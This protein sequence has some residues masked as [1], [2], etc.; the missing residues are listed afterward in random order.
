MDTPSPVDPSKATPNSGAPTPDTPE[1]GWKTWYARERIQLV[2]GDASRFETDRPKGADRP[3]FHILGTCPSCHHRTSA[4]CAAKY[5]AVDPAVPETARFRADYRPRLQA[6]GPLGRRSGLPRSKRAAGKSQTMITVV[7]CGCIHNHVPPAD[8]AFGC[9]SEWLLRVTFDSAGSP[10]L[11]VVPEDEA[12]RV[13]PAAEE[14]ASHVPTSLAD[15]QATAKNWAA[16]L[17]AVLT[18]LGAGSLLAN[19][20]TVQTLSRSWQLA[21]GVFAFAAVIANGVMLYQSNF[22]SY[23]SPKINDALS[24][25]DPEV[26]DLD[27]L[28]DA[29]VSVRKLQI[30]VRMTVLAVVCALIAIGILLFV[31]SAPPALQPATS[32][33]T[34]RANGVITTTACGT[35]V[36]ST[37]SS[38]GTPTSVTFVPDTTNAKRQTLPL[39]EVKSIAAC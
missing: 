14:A 9:G 11:A 3:G 12:S 10:L 21:F 26:A 7:T 17:T 8:G 36:L 28:V 23:G 27:P 38:G 29:Q 39:A 19:R 33:I 5:L 22:A 25:S 20:T 34:Y 2:D 37:T 15:A 4:V 18:L 30:A 6:F 35:V 32:K 13:W 24:A 31:S 1:G 16:A